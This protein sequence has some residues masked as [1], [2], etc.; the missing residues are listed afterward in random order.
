MLL[1]LSYFLLVIIEGCVG[2]TSAG[3]MCQGQN[4]SVRIPFESLDQC[5]NASRKLQA[6]GGYQQYV[7]AVCLA[8]PNN[9][10]KQV[11]PPPS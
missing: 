10:P 11:P 5:E 1:N 9:R 7:K 8:V 2:P 6:P 4:F 3:Q